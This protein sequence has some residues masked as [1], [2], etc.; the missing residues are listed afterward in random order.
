MPISV[1]RNLPFSLAWGAVVTATITAKNSYD[2]SEPSLPGGI[3]KILRVPD[4]PINFVNV[5]TVTTGTQIGLK[6]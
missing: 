4:V 6:W 5:P 3:G 1:L 2:E